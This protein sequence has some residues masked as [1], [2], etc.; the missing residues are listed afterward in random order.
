MRNWAGLALPFFGFRYARML[1]SELLTSSMKAA[2]KNLSHGVMFM[3]CSK[4]D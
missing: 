1:G 3:I 4:H 2:I